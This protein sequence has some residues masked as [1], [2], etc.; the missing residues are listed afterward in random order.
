MEQRRLRTERLKL[1]P[2]TA[3]QPGNRRRHLVAGRRHDPGR[4][5]RRRR[6]RLPDRLRNP[7]QVRRRCGQGLRCCDQKRRHVGLQSL[8]VGTR[9]IS[10]P[11]TQKPPATKGGVLLAASSRPTTWKPPRVGAV[12]MYSVV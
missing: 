11:P 5:G 2:V 6:R 7:T 1:L 4:R 10:C 9:R 8:R 3:E 12:A